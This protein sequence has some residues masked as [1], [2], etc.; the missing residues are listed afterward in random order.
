MVLT[1]IIIMSPKVKKCTFGHVC[2][3]KIKVSLHIAQSSESPLDPFR[4]AKDAKF[5]HVGSKDVDQAVQM[6]R[7]I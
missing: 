2:P 6:R 1:T 5:F 4:I 3:A 7:L